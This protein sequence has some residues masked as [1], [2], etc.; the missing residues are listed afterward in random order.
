MR[1]ATSRRHACSPPPHECVVAI[2]ATPSAGIASGDPDVPSEMT[3]TGS[4]RLPMPA[5]DLVQRTGHMD[6][7][8]PKGGCL[9]LHDD[10]ADRRARG[11]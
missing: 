3:T 1:R 6:K 2:M 10:L 7:V 8:D 4:Q 5:R 9:R 11:A